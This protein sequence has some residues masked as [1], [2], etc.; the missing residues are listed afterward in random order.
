[1]K[2][3]IDRHG[4]VLVE[5]RQIGSGDV[6]ELYLTATP[7]GGGPTES[8][9]RQL[10]TAVREKLNAAGGR[11]FCERLFA[12]ADVVPTIEKVRREVYADLDDGIPPTRVV[13]SPS[14]TGG[15]FAGAQIHA[16]SSAAR[17][18]AL[19]CCD[20]IDGTPARVFNNNGNRWLFINGLNSVANVSEAEQ[21]RRMFF[22]TGCFLRQAGASMKSVARTWL[23]LKDICD[24][25]DDFNAARTSFF[26]SEGLIDRESRTTRLPASTGIGLHGANGAA[27]TLDLIALPGREDQIQLVEAGGDQ[28]SAFDYGSAFSRA[29]VAPMPGGKTVFVSGTAAIDRTGDTE[30]I[31][32]IEAQVD[33]TVAHVRSLLG[34]LGCGDEHVLTALVYCK[35]AAVERTFRRRWAQLPWPRITMIGDVCRPELLFE[36]EVT[37]SPEL[38]PDRSSRGQVAG[39]SGSTRTM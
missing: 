19:R 38:A 14:P 26:H 23:W 21:A 4:S 7:G 12:T 32:Q 37:A 35:S 36:I 16:I 27:C 18:S 22:C 20:L 17:P 15:S 1:M 24:W 28:K 9:A 34:Q 33:N 30:H 5:T 8:R 39:P 25:Y 29:S 13:V 10:Y 31:G 11:L 2:S 3:K 6:A